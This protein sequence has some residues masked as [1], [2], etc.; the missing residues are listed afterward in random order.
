MAHSHYGRVHCIRYLS[1]KSVCFF[2][3]SWYGRRIDFVYSFVGGFRVCKKKTG[4]EMLA[5]MVDRPISRLMIVNQLTRLH[6]SH[7]DNPELES[8]LLHTPSV[9]KQHAVVR[10]TLR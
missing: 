10:I 9:K 8:P 3:S 2:K 5:L 1:K 7:F 6:S 4:I